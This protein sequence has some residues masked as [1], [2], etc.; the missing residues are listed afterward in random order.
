MCVSRNEILQHHLPPL[1]LMA[2]LTHLRGL[3][4]IYSSAFWNGCFFLHFGDGGEIGSALCLR[5]SLNKLVAA[6]LLLVFFH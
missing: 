2:S 6:Q 5:S 3:D 4:C 1:L